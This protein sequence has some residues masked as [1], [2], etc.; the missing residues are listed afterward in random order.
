[1][2]NIYVCVSIIL[3]IFIA[4]E[5]YGHSDHLHILWEHLNSSIYSASDILHIRRD[6][7]KQRYRT[8]EVSGAKAKYQMMWKSNFP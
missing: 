8:A 4:G 1:M 3:H 7:A 5:A 6:A 2:K